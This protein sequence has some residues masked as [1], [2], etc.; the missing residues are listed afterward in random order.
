MLHY[1]DLKKK[2]KKKQRL[3]RCLSLVTFIVVL[4]AMMSLSAF[5]DTPTPTALAGGL[6]MT[7]L[8]E[9]LFS[10]FSIVIKGLASGLK[11]AF[12]N[13]IYVDPAATDPVFSPLVIFLFVMAGLGL[14]TGILYKIFGMIQANRRG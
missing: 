11:E 14:A 7:D 6:G 1:P 3:R 2:Q 10:S 13:L 12:G 8:I 9:E 5:A 4:C